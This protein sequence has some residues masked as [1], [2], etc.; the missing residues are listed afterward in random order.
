MHRLSR[1]LAGVVA[2]IAVVAGVLVPPPAAQAAAAEGIF[3]MPVSGRVAHLVKGCP[4]GSRPTHEGVDINL[5]SNTPIYA[6]AGGTVTTATNSNA[7]SGYGS[8]VVITH[9]SGHTTRYA[10][11][12]Y[13]SLAVKVGAVVPRGTVLGRVGST[14]N[15]T[16][17]HLH[18]E[19][20]RNGVNVTNR[21]FI[22]GQVNVT[23][24]APLEPR[25]SKPVNAD[26]NADGK[27]D[28]LGVS[29]AGRMTAYNGNG[30]G[31]WASVALGSGWGTT[32]LMVHGDFS[33]D[34][35]GDFVAARTD[36]SLWLYRGTG[37][38]R[39]AA[40]Q[41]GRGWNGLTM[42]SGGADY[43][44]DGIAD[45]VAV[46]GDGYL[47]LYAGTGGGGVTAAGTIAQG[48]ANNDAMVAG[49]FNGD[50]AGDI[51]A[52]DKAGK[53]FFYPGNGSGVGAPTQVGQGWSGV[54]ALTGGAD[55][56]G[57]GRPDLLARDS[58]G[59]LWLYPWLGSAFGARTKVGNGWNVHRLIL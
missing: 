30:K 32:R 42:I 53:L 31:G 4:A 17:P 46:G 56:T 8:Q 27:A 43:N 50:G 59:S 55:Y 10:H 39:F 44:S 2:A 38:N 35:R 20:F 12:V 26:Y 15:S 33:G 37:G 51:M 58:A 52:R 36:G 18:F 22:C 16:G 57:D 48:W 3:V 34:N 23:A 54:T 24:L 47:Y 6:A 41:I 29:S 9:P 7:T 19:M 28:I 11:M 49:D 45:L 21:Y 5:N 1:L 13:G 40:S 14:G 25:P